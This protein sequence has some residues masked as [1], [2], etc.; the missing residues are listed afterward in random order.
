VVFVRNPHYFRAGKPYLDRII[1]DTNANP[2][3]IALG[4]EKG[5]LQGAALAAELTAADIQHA[6]PRL[7]AL[8]EVWASRQPSPVPRIVNA[9]SRSATSVGL[10][11]DRGH[12]VPR[13]WRLD[14]RETLFCIHL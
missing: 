12:G 1:A 4:V 8:Q 7:A 6:L 14:A 13:G 3:A 10:T 11:I 9:V 2:S 5:A